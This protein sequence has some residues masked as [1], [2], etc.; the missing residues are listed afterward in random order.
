M[1]R[2]SAAVSARSN[3]EVAVAGIP[4]TLRCVTAGAFGCL[5][6]AEAVAR[7]PAADLLRLT[8]GARARI[9]WCEQA[10]GDSR[11]VT[12][13]GVGLRLMGLDTAERG[14]PRP[15]LGRIGSYGKPLLTPRGDRVVFTDWP[16]RTI[17]IVNWAGTS[18]VELG[19]GLAAAVWLDPATGREW[20]YG[21]APDRM[22]TDDAE[23]KPLVRFEIDEPLRRET[24]WDATAVTF[25]N[26]RLSADGSMLGALF[27][28]PDA[29]IADLTTRRLTRLGRGCWT[30]LAP[31]RSGLLWVFDGAHRNVVI[32]TPDGRSRWTVPIDGA[33]GI[34]GSEVYHPRWSNRLRFLCMTGPYRVGGGDNRIRGGGEGVEVYVGRLG[35]RLTAVEDWVRITDNRR[36]DFH[37]D[38]WVDP[39]GGEPD[40]AEWAGPASSNEASASD[41]R[42]VV[43]AR[44]VEASAVPAPESIA[45]YRHALAVHAFEVVGVISGPL[46]GRRVRVA[47]WA[48]RDGRRTAAASRPGQT[49]RLTLEPYD[50]HRELEGERMVMGLSSSAGPLM[51]DVGSR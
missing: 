22:D 6:V 46:E 34:D 19:P 1:S 20:V 3:H 28:W 41:A 42:V 30:S 33:P 18:R 44:L 9:V 25:D 7:E 40:P 5:G 10:S 31:G 26:V 21:F 35:A 38:L 47:Q 51:Y 16:T 15:I 14:A 29:G 13:R 17:H 49:V 12:A 24:V 48:I 39:S 43:D 36:A 2:S 32:H 27:P 4:A 11:D 50:R 8:G 37:P 45:P 23:G